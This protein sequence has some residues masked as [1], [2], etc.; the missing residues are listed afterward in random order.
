MRPARKDENRLVS[1]YGLQVQ[2]GVP[3]SVQVGSV[4]GSQ[5]V[6]GLVAAFQFREGGFLDAREEE[7]AP[8]QRNDYENQ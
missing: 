5:Q 1:G 8:C 7:R 4:Q 6:D 2:E 3:V